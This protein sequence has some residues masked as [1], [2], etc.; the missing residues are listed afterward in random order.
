MP[1]TFHGL[2][3]ERVRALQ[4]GACDSNDQTPEHAVSD[5]DGVPCRHCLRMIG[6]GEPYLVLAN[7]PFR[8]VQ[9]YAEVGPI[10]LHAEPCEPYNG[11]PDALPP[12][13]RDSFD[14]I[15][16]GYGADERIVYGTG[17][18]CPQDEIVDRAAAILG[19]DDVAFVHVRSSRDNCW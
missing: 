5:G 2:P 12:V 18:V 11:E 7:R 6:E 13:L 16:R 14:F 8:T 10:F 15:V 17:G 19:R 9:P 1:V 3:T 4:N